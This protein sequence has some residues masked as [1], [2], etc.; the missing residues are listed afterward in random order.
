MS[1]QVYFRLQHGKVM[2]PIAFT[3]PHI[4][5]IDLKLA[6][7]EKKDMTTGFDFDLKISDAEN[8]SKL[9]EGDDTFVPK[10]ASVVAKRMPVPVGTGILSRLKAR[11]HGNGYASAAGS[12]DIILPTKAEENIDEV[13]VAVK[14]ENA[15]QNGSSG[16]TADR[17]TPEPEFLPE[18]DEEELAM[19][20]SITE[21]YR[22][23]HVC[24]VVGC[25]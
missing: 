9:Y 23:T 4:K 19:L 12:N 20:R 5:L 7:L 13:D 25:A 17:S 6:I 10:N 24:C 2:E 14:E 21:R 16:A 1:S 22:L 3:G 8:S 15:D 18:E 11:G